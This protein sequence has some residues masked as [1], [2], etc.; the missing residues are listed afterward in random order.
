MTTIEFEKLKSDLDYG[1]Q[2][3]AHLV[4]N[5]NEINGNV[6]YFEDEYVYIQEWSSE[7]QISF[8]LD[9]IPKT[10]FEVLR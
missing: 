4:E 1:K 9:N 2:I 7:Q 3:I 8:K 6:L 5:G 10:A